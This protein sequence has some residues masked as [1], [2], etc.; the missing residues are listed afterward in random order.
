MKLPKLGT[1]TKMH[2]AITP[3]SVM[4]NVIRKKPA[5]GPAPRS[6]AASRGERPK[7]SIEAYSGRI[8]NGR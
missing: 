5:T 1:N 8:I 3:G 7:R 4:G 2:P 6:A